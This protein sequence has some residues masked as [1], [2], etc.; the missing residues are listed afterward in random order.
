MSLTK[1][2]LIAAVCATA[3]VFPAVAAAEPT[4]DAAVAEFQALGL[5]PLTQ[6]PSGRVVPPPRTRGS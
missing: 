5:T 6:F 2:V 1:K 4:V 3:G